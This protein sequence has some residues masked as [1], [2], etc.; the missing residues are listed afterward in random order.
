MYGEYTAEGMGYQGNALDY[1]YLSLDWHY[2]LTERVAY[3]PS[4]YSW[5]RRPKP[6]RLV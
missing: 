2:L 3:V 1:E 4:N 5:V 6:G